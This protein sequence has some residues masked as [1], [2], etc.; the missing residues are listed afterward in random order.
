MKLL[1]TMAFVLTTTSALA[2]PWTVPDGNGGWKDNPECSSASC[3]DTGI[4]DKPEVTPP[5]PEIP[6]IPNEPEKPSVPSEP[7]KPSVPSE[8]EK[9][10]VPEV[11]AKNVKQD[12]TYKAVNST[13]KLS[14][15]ITIQY[16]ICCLDTGIL[17][18]SK[19]NGGDISVAKSQCSSTRKVA[20][21]CSDKEK[22]KIFK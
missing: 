8:P 11:P 13:K 19:I 3:R 12:P 17:Y 10:S 4:P 14:Q 5:K 7:E 21:Q 20:K 6:S 22:A 9:P 2:T 16:G 1:Y 15:P 18:F